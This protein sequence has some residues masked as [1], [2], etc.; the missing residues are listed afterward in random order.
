MISADARVDFK[1]LRAAYDPE[2]GLTSTND[3]GAVTFE[4]HPD[5]TLER[6]TY[7][8]EKHVRGASTRSTAREN[9][10]MRVGLIGLSMFKRMLKYHC[11]P[12][13][14]CF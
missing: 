3:A 5:G 13:I 7:V 10:K 8:P 9:M 14:N 2:T 12:S 1:S 11:E 6:T 4:I